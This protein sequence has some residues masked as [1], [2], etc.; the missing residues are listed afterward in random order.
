MTLDERQTTKLEAPPARV[1]WTPGRLISGIIGFLLVV[2]GSVALFRLLPSEFLG[3]AQVE[4]LGVG[5]TVLMAVLAIGLGLLFIAESVYFAPTGMA[6][7]GVVSFAFGLIVV[8][9]ESTFRESLGVGDPGGWL[10][11]TIGIISIVMGLSGSVYS[12]RA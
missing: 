12:R 9:E 5:H 3:T 6:I 11:L 1:T 2:M 4:V 7:L 10:Y 8:L